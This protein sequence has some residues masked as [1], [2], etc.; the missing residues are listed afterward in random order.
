MPRNFEVAILFGMEPVRLLLFRI[1]AWWRG[2]YD[3][4]AY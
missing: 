1:L 4:V 2:E 3:A